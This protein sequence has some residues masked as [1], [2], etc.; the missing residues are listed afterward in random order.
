MSDSHTLPLACICPKRT[1]GL[2]CTPCAN[3]MLCDTPQRSPTALTALRL[4][5]Y[6]TPHASPALSTCLASQTAPGEY[7][8]Y[9]VLGLSA[10]AASSTD[11]ETPNEASPSPPILLL[12]TTTTATSLQPEEA[13][14][15][16]LEPSDWI[17]TLRSEAASP[18]LQCLSLVA[19]AQVRAWALG[20]AS[21]SLMA[22]TP[23]GGHHLE[24]DASKAT[25]G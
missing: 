9:S 20:T 14:N 25:S 13:S 8:L 10:S 17:L 6:N 18:L 19:T 1:Y 3:D 16:G 15:S 11:V 23:C 22:L 24:W 4:L 5:T 7:V 21:A 12:D 2:A